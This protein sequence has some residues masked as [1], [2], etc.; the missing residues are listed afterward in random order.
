MAEEIQYTANTG[1]VTISSANSNLDGSGDIYKVLVGAA[2][3][4]V[5][6][7]VTIKAITSTKKGMVRLLYQIVQRRL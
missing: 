6:K 4:T 5:I 3:G 2:N 7:T 1:M